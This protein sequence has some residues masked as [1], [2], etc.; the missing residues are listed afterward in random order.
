[1]KAFNI[2]ITLL[3]IFT[4]FSCEDI[5]EK[6]LSN[7]SLITIYP[8]EGERIESNV[9]NFQWE[10][11][12]GVENYHLQVFNNKDLLIKDTI[13]KKSNLNISLPEG[14]YKWKMRGENLAYYS[15][16]TN[17]TSFKISLSNDLSKQQIVL[18]SPTNEFYTNS[19]TFNLSWQTL[20]AISSYTLQIINITNANNIVLEQTGIS[21]NTFAMNSSILEKDGKYEWKIK[22]LNSFSETPFSNRFFYVDTTIPNQPQNVLPTNNSKYN[23]NTNIP[24]SWSIEPDSGIIKSTIENFNIDFSTDNSFNTILQTSTTTANNFQR[25]FNTP[26]DYY[27]RV[28]AK[29]KAGNI[30]I[31]S[32]TYKLT[33]N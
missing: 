12:K 24:F 7:E 20:N 14:L 2:Y 11:L 33:I 10:K 17:L 28:R 13:T 27:W 4:F 16:F 21:N 18:L 25:S 29:D 19:K 5:L 1:M 23:I 22:G 9:I 3:F 31:Y 32:N 6:D 8:K 15:Q 26:G 30:S